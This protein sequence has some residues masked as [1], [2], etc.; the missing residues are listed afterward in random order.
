MTVT[1]LIVA[2]WIAVHGQPRETRVPTADALIVFA[3]REFQHALSEGA[4]VRVRTVLLALA[5][6]H[7]CKA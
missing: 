4:A 3:C 7:P 2:R 5:K 1:S 6:E